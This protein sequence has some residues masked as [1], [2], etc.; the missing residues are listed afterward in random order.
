M[1]RRAAKFLSI[2]IVSTSLAFRRGI[3]HPPSF[4]ASIS[5]SSTSSS[6][7]FYESTVLKAVVGASADR[8]KFG[9]KVLRCY[10]EH[11]MAVVPINKKSVEIESLKCIPSLSQL[12]KDITPAIPMSKVGVSIIT[13]PGVT[14]LI[15]KEAYALGVRQFLLQPG[16][17]DSETDKTIATLENVN[18][19]KS[20]VLVDLGFSEH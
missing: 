12:Q 4:M 19:F 6:R 14:A 3:I 7:T 15:L 20:C 2:C 11:S 17:Y 10:Q 1:A 9:N 16:T 5:M 13:P 8:S 18:V